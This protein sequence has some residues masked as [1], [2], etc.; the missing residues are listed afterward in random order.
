MKK[1]VQK[2]TKLEMFLEEIDSIEE[3]YQLFIGAEDD[4]LYVESS[5][6]GEKDYVG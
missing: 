1:K 5:E 6:T 3:K 4:Q 2:K